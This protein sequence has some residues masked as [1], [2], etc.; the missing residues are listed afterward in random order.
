[1][2]GIG[3]V[4]AWASPVLVVAVVAHVTAGGL[5]A[6]LFVLAALAAP[7]LALLASPERPVT[8]SGFATTLGLVSVVCV[9]GAGFRTVADVGQ[10]LGLETGATV[11]AVLVLV[12]VTTV[13]RDHHRV[14]ATALVV[15]WGALLVALVMLAGS[16]GVA[17]W[18]AW[19]RVA[20]RG[21]FEL[22]PRSE[23]TREGAQF[24]EPTTLTFTEPHRIVALSDA[25][26]RV[27]ERDRGTAVR[28]RKLAAGESLAL[29]P[30]DSLA[31]PAGVRLRFEAGR[32]IPGAP[33]GVAWADGTGVSRRRLS[34]WWVGLTLTLAGG[35]LMIVRPVPS[36]SRASAVGGPAVV[37]TIVVAATCWGLYAIDTAPELTLGVPAAAQLVRLAPV[38]ADEPWRS[39]ILAS[40]VLALLALFLAAAAALR[41][42]LIDLTA[43]GTTTVRRRLIEAAA[44]IVMVVAAAGTS[45][46]ATDGFTLLLHGAGL[47]TAVLLGPL[48]VSGTGP[49]VDSARAK[50]ALVGAL[51]F[52][53]LALLARWVGPLG[54]I[55]V[56]TQY[57]ALLA[58]PAAWLVAILSRRGE[59]GRV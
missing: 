8:S 20:S 1:M 43:A 54:L 47:A 58:A 31:I 42:S 4:A 35:A 40:I 5:E 17:P 57:P 7:L 36:P 18:T 22:G 27:T 13:W 32:R 52:V 29:R 24:G 48:L 25:V 3:A 14:A 51:I 45:L 41:H 16:A 56:V 37:F 23:W 50:G 53:L 55:G 21:T 46:L 49:T 6:P 2:T 15:G 33:S 9:L 44:W 39:R 11:G 34:V 59:S 26:V 10:V 19:S 30:G 12:L 28:D 38:V